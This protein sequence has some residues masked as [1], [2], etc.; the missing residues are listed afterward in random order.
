[1]SATDSGRRRAPAPAL[2]L[3]DWLRPPSGYVTDCALGTS[4]SL[5]LVTCLAAL[6]TLDGA[7]QDTAQY[8]LTAALRALN[9]L[10][11][12]VR[13]VVQQGRIHWTPGTDPAVLPLLD[14]VVRP[15]TPHGEGSFHPKVWVVRQRPLGEGVDVVR[16]ALVV[17]SRNLTR[18]RSWDLGV[19]LEGYV[20]EPGGLRR[21]NDPLPTSCASSV[22]PA[23]SRASSRTSISAPWLEAAARCA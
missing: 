3:L 2:A 11:E 10:S 8:S 1:M 18:D 21:H 9:R 20:G 15:V 17:G 16:Y 7:A 13:V 22:R 5:D 14:R 4:Y 19:A 6:V 12:S 23:G